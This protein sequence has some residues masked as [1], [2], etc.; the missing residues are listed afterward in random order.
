MMGAICR[1]KAF[2]PHYTDVILEKV[3]LDHTPNYALQSV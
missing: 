3:L 2:T 1:D